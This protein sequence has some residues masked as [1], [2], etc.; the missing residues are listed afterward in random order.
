MPYLRISAAAHKGLDELLSALWSHVL[1][2]GSEA[3]AGDE[4]EAP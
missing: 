4:E 1:A 2:Q 3:E